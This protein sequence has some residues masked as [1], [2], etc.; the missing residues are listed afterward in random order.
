M[1]QS[2]SI[3]VFISFYFE[4]IIGALRYYVVRGETQCLV[5][6]VPREGKV[7][8]ETQCLVNYVPREGKVRK[9][10]GFLI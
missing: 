3:F 2:N 1:D 8:G 7:R 6:Y 5:N 9:T 4:L 10:V